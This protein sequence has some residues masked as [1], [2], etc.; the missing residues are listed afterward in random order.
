MLAKHARQTLDRIKLRSKNRS[1][2]TLHGV[3]KNHGDVRDDVQ[4]QREQERDSRHV[5]DMGPDEVAMA[6]IDRKLAPPP[7][8]RSATDMVHDSV[9]CNDGSLP[10]KREAKAEV[11]IL[12][13]A[14]E[15]LVESARL[16]ERGTPVRGSC[17][18]RGEGGTSSPFNIRAFGSSP[19]Q[20]SASDATHVIRVAD[21]IDDRVRGPR[22]LQRSDAGC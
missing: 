22:Q 8:G 4:R 3:N 12:H 9:G 17:G 7:T 15:R 13:V 2:A 18:A 10:S 20:D 16:Q 6:V 14:E 11:N 21:A 1:A 19:V 5:L